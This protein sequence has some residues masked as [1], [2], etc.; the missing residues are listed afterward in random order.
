MIAPMPAKKSAQPVASPVSATAARRR[1]SAARVL[2]Q[3]RI[4][5][6]AVKSHFRAVEKKAG[7][8][9]AQLWALSVIHESPGLGMNDLAAAMDVHQSTASNL[10]RALAERE[11]VVVRKNAADRRT[12]QLHVLAAGVRVLR[13][14][15]GP[16]AGVLPAALADLDPRTLKRLEQDLAKLIATLDVGEEAG[17]IP[18]G[19]G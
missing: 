13:R 9:G 8:A 1:E 11:L 3:F 2:R 17:S 16:F 6:N 12:V 18:L 4:V 19:D 15:P 10:V 7:V 14:A 5:F